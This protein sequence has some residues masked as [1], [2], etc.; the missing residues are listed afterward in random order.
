MTLLRDKIVVEGGK[1]L[2]ALIDGQHLRCKVAD[3]VRARPAV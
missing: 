2:G 1:L 3:E